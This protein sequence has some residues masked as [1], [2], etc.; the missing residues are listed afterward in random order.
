MTNVHLCNTYRQ[1]LMALS[2]IMAKGERATVIYLQDYLPIGVPEQCRLQEICSNVEFVYTSDA[3]E[4]QIFR[5]LPR[6]VP[7]ILSRNIRLNRYGMPVR[8]HDWRPDYLSGRSFAT[9][10]VYHSGFFMSKIIA[11]ISNEI[12]LREDGY[13]N[14]TPHNVRGYLKQ[15]IRWLSGLPPHIQI[16]G[17]E[18]WVTRI[19]M[20]SPDQL[21][22]SIR[23]KARQLLFDDLMKAIPA[24]TACS[25]AGTFAPTSASFCKETVAEKTVLLLT[26]PIEIAGM[27]SKERKVELYQGVVD[28]MNAHDCR[29]FVKN[30]PRES[31]FELQRTITI[32]GSFP[33]EAWPFV[34]RMRFDVG[35]ALCT[36]ALLDNKMSFVK[37]GVQLITPDTFFAHA[38]DTWPSQIDTNLE[39]LEQYLRTDESRDAD[40]AGG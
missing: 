1:M 29:V 15:L 25:L 31:L 2:D 35:V 20:S 27:C 36:S 13:T 26:Q 34:T 16:F 32:P 10:Y 23:Y 28:W 4:L 21:P 30:H 24:S 14:Y 6:W 33:I 40:G 7:G 22:P 19:E 18:K 8:P 37:K 39:K 5:Q 17:E 11:G 38:T 12:V 9:G 3:K